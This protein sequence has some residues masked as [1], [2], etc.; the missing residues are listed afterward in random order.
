MDLGFENFASTGVL[1]ETPTES[2]RR[3]LPSSVVVGPPASTLPAE[4]RRTV[5]R[6]GV[7]MAP[8]RSGD[9]L[10]HLFMYRQRCSTG[11]Q[12]LSKKLRNPLPVAARCWI[13]GRPHS[14]TSR[15]KHARTM[16]AAKRHLPLRRRGRA[17]LTSSK[18]RAQLDSGALDPRTRPRINRITG[19]DESATFRPFGIV[20]CPPPRTATAT[21][22][23]FSGQNVT[24]RR[25]WSKPR[26]LH[27]RVTRRDGDKPNAGIRVNRTSGRALS[28]KALL[29]LNPWCPRGRR[30]A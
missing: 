14:P 18:T 29:V 16:C 7:P 23:G 24:Q 21:V 28:R 3:Y 9:R 12:E 1:V 8:E 5:C 11:R 25:C 27:A 13:D 10:E 2:L 19:R 15:S 26:G 20:R 17:T 6:L 22:G 30:F 4:V